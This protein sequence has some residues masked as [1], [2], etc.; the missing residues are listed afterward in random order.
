M[1]VKPKLDFFGDLATKNIYCAIYYRLCDCLE[2][3]RF[4]RLGKKDCFFLQENLISLSVIGQWTS[5]PSYT[6]CY[7]LK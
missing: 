2:T 7:A 1:S 3:Y 6:N 5:E 4:N